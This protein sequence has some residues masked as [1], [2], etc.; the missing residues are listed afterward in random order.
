MSAVWLCF[1]RIFAVL[2]CKAF[3]CSD[4]LE[5]SSRIPIPN[6]CILSELQQFQPACLQVL[7]KSIGMTE[8]SS[9][10]EQAFWCSVCKQPVSNWTESDYVLQDFQ[11]DSVSFPSNAPLVTEACYWNRYFKIAFASRTLNLKVFFV[12]LNIF[13]SLLFSLK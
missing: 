5:G 2:I 6:S 1:S 4:V 11:A 10:Q 3:S 13:F 12:V 7:L 8:I 9:W